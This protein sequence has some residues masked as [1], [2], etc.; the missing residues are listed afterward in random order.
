MKILLADLP[1]KERGYN[2]TYPSLA[3]TYLIGYARN[4]FRNQGHE[5]HYLDG[6]R[7]LESLLKVV[8]E[9]KPDVFGATVSA[10]TATLAYTTL[11]AVRHTFPNIHVICGGAH[12]TAAPEGVLAQCAAD[13]CVHGEGEVTFTELIEHFAGTGKPLEEIEGVV[14]RGPDGKYIHTPHRPYIRDLDSIPM[15]AWDMVADF[16]VY[17]GMHFRKAAPQSYV[18]CSRGCPFDCN[19]C[20][21]PVWKVNKPWVRMRS[22][23]KIAEE[24]QWI[25]ELGV[26]EIYLGA[27]E[28]NVK[29]DW[30]EEVCDRIAALHHEDLYFHIDARA[31]QLPARLAQKLAGINVWLAHLGIESGNQRTID[32]IGKRVTL[33]QI[34]DACRQFQDAGIKVFG[35]LMLFHA[36]ENSHGKLCWESADDVDKTIAFAKKLLKEGLVNYISWQVA[37]PLPGSRLWDVAEVYDLTVDPSTFHGIRTMAMRLPGVSERDV[38]RAVRKGVA[39][40]TYYAARSGDINA[41]EIYRRGRE[42]MKNI[43]GVGTFGGTE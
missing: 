15:P 38:A 42:S 20:S 34:I 5:F 4:H 7:D 33:E 25:Y 35:F 16:T 30:A 23:E 3:M 19:F 39:L 11:S 14:F 32:G 31:D 9:T 22:P 29:V 24:V 40:K 26:R 8:R 28:L 18:L 41:R 36:W 13:L 10:M 1:R 6:H 37:T 27:D 12:P 2:L 17:P 21:N 43:I